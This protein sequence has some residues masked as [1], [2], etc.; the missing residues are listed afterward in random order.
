MQLKIFHRGGAIL[1]IMPLIFASCHVMLIGAYDQV[2]D[3]SI[4]H[5]Q[6]DVST[7]LVRV[8]KNITDGTA[9]NN[10]YE[11]LKD[12]YDNIEGQI[13]SLKTRVSA[14]PKYKIISDQVALLENNVIDM[15]K[16]N[17]IGFT[18]I[19]PVRVIDSTFQVQFSAMIALQNGLK[20]EKTP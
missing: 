5:I 12:A 17:K 13:K 1:L 16:F 11:N 14:L 6:T 18:D 15:E 9:N 10:K 8:E 7:L 20:R 4:Q 3:Q 19:E 2:T